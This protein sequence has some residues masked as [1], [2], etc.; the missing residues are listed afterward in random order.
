MAGT[1][2][3]SSE[4]DG[5]V[6]RAVSGSLR[7]LP[8]TTQTTR[9]SEKSEWMNL[10]NNE[11]TDDIFD[12]LEAFAGDAAA[13]GLSPVQ[14]AVQWLLEQPGVSSIVVGARRIEQLEVLLALG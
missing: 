10:E 3:G 2:A 9:L 4:K 12:Q 7:P 14:Y 5:E 1:S 11:I 13:A 8:V 6:D